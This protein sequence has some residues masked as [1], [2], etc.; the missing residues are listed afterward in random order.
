[1]ALRR[2]NI[3]R[4]RGLPSCKRLAGNLEEF[5]CQ[6][7]HV[8]GVLELAASSETVAATIV[9]RS[10]QNIRCLDT[11]S[12]K[13]DT[14][15]IERIAVYP[16]VLNPSKGILESYAG[17]AG[18]FDR[19]QDFLSSALGLPVVAQRIELDLARALEK[20]ASAVDRFQLRDVRLPNYSLSSYV[21]G[22]L[23]ACFTDT[24]HGLDFVQ[25]HSDSLAGATVRYQASSGRVSLRLSAE[26]CFAYAC[27]EEDDLNVR[28]LLRKLVFSR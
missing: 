23:S 18:G 5:G 6:K 20:L 19:L 8:F 27:K 14:K 9:H 3:A 15:L 12:R 25:K 28:S 26:A 17:T 4:I 11:E 10:Q 16:V 2:L 21:V 24:E 7:N 1:M 22:S 13:V